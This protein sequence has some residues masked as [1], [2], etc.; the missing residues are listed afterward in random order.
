MHRMTSKLWVPLLVAAFAACVPLP[1]SVKADAA[2]PPAPKTNA[3]VPTAT[4]A[5]ALRITLI[6]SRD[7]IYVGEGFG[8]RMRLENVSG[9]PIYFTPRAFSLMAPTELDPNPG[10]EWFFMFPLIQDLQTNGQ[11]Y[12]RTTPVCLMPN[13]NIV[14]LW[15]GQ[16]QNPEAAGV[17]KLIRNSFSP[18]RFSPGTYTLDVTGRYWDTREGA[19]SNDGGYTQS[20]EIKQAFAEPWRVILTGAAI[21]GFFAYFL[22][23]RFDPKLYSG[24]GQRTWASAVS[25]MVLSILVTI[26]L[27]RLSDTQFVIRVTVNDFWGAMA[28]GFVGAA[29]G[30]SV[31]KKFTDYLEKGANGAGGTKKTQ[32]EE[33]TAKP[34]LTP[35]LSKAA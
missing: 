29:A 10:S 19:I 12:D 9:R 32:A 7:Q 5:S 13:S 4:A 14:A 2:K 26:L 30:P 35:E 3:S 15:K 20:E 8:I 18:F 23:W 24:W 34:Q 16:L 31:L 17:W 11:T 27:A 28:V 22:V 21:G 6:S 33:L 1:V 25:A